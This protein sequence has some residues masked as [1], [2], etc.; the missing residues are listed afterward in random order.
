MIAIQT[1]GLWTLV[2]AFPPTNPCTHVEAEILRLKIRGYGKKLRQTSN[3]RACSI[4]PPR[5][6][7]T[8]SFLAATTAIL[9][10]QT[11]Y[12]ST[13]VSVPCRI[14]HLSGLT[15]VCSN[16]GMDLA[17]LSDTSIRTS[18]MCWTHVSRS[19]ISRCHSRGFTSF[20]HGQLLLLSVLSLITHL[21]TLCSLFGLI[22][23]LRKQGG[24][25]GETVF[26]DVSVLDLAALAYLPQV[27]RF[28][29]II[30]EQGVYVE[31][32]GAEYQE[33]VFID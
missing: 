25:D 7:L 16:T 14:K 13:S 21:F 29:I 23:N 12:F 2:R 24:F 6:G 9:L 22:H 10:S 18:A 26:D 11:S 17:V 32:E 3:T 20:C 27:T 1:Y 31:D 15:N 28:G 19:W 33:E 8:Y 30:D 4:L 5:S